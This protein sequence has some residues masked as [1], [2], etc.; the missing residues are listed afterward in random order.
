MSLLERATVRSFTIDYGPDIEEEIARLGREI[1]R[2]PQIFTVFPQRWLAVKLLEQDHEIQQK[3][4]RIEG[5]PAVLTH[6][7][8]GCTHLVELFGPGC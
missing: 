5:G 8:I 2:Y 7:Q 4:L 3:L 6:A 1:A